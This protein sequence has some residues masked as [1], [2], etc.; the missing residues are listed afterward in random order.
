MQNEEENSTEIIGA[1][2]KSFSDRYWCPVKMKSDSYNV[3][4]DSWGL[5]P[6]S[7][8]N[9]A[10]AKHVVLTEKF[11]FSKDTFNAIELGSFDAKVPDKSLRGSISEFLNLGHSK[12]FL[13]YLKY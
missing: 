8:M 7:C 1:C 12:L 3:K 2:K 5:C 4:T 10:I 9:N 13:L 11:K 6:L